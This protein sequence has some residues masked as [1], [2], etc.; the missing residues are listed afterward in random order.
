MK[1]DKFS[2]ISVVVAGVIA[3]T[4]FQD[5]IQSPPEAA[6]RAPVMPNWAAISAWPGIPTDVIEAQPDP[7]RRVTA[8]VL[9]DSGSMGDDIEAAKRAVVG[10]LNAM[11]ADDR[12]A[13]L[14]L[15]AGTILPF[16]SVTD[17][18]GALSNLLRP[19]VSDG[20]TPL[21][22]SIQE[23]QVLL[24]AEAATMRS[25]GTFRLIVT[26]DG[27]ADD[28]EALDAAIEA[29]AASTPI[30]V[31][32]IGIGIDGGHVLRRDDLGSFVDV[33]NVEAL[34]QA[35]QAA[36]AENADFTAITDFGETEG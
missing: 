9:D 18:Q 27:E 15:N 10:A 8:I 17:A 4:I 16:T 24:E 6:E 35:L 13:V 11:G 36:V 22:R 28:G 25:F 2:V 12:V 14:A 34:E 26:T 31:T 5:N 19:I 23:A 3:F 7:N 20:S 33:A 29:L 32:T 21:T 1:W 30:Q